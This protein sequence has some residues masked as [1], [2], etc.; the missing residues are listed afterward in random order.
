MNGNILRT[1]SGYTTRS[2][3]EQKEGAVMSTKDIKLDR[4]ATY[5]PLWA[6]A[7]DLDM[8]LLMRISPPNGRA[9]QA[10]RSV[11]ASRPSVRS[12]TFA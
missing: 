6:T 2:E 11:S 1:D 5:E 9:F 4:H 7:Q 12:A 8:P 3:R 10:A